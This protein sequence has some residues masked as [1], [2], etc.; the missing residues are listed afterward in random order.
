MLIV[1][2]VEG[3]KAGAIAYFP[4]TNPPDGW[5][6]CNGAQISRT[7]YKKLFDYIGTV[8]G[9]GDGVTTFNL[10]D[11]RG[12]FIRSWADNGSL[13]AGRGFG[14]IQS[15]DF[16]SH[17]HSIAQGY[18]GGT[19][20]AGYTPLTTSNGI[21]GTQYS[22]TSGGSENRPRNVALLVCIKF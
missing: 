18:Y 13:D 9:A 20:G 16:A 21:G 6:K 8:H 1:Q 17:N 3:V 4:V 15:Q 2:P 7:A 11:L 10:P 22:G 14:G 19:T 12:E 5:V